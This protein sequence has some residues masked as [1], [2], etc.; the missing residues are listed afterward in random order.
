MRGLPAGYNE[1]ENSPS[2]SID[3]WLETQVNGA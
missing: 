1:I 3:E 2:I